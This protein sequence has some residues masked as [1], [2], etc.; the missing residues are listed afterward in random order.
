MGDMAEDMRALKEYNKRRRARNAEKA[1]LAE[2]LAIDGVSLTRNDGHTW[3]LKLRGSTLIYWLPSGKWQWNG[4][5]T[6]GGFTSFMNWLKQES[7]T[8]L[9]PASP[10]PAIERA[11]KVNEDPNA[12]PWKD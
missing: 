12:P 2:V 3:I 5:V 8:S 6:A 7:K 10:P 4:R 9:P 11:W 1:N